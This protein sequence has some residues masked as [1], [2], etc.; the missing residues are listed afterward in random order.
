[1]GTGALS[2]EAK[3]PGCE[4][5]HSPSSSAEVKER[6]ELYLYSPNML[7]WRRAHLKAQGQLHLHLYVFLNIRPRHGIKI[8]DAVKHNLKNRF[9]CFLQY[10]KPKLNFIEVY[11]TDHST[12]KLLNFLTRWATVSFSRTMFH[13]VSSVVKDS[14]GGVCTT[15]GRNEK[16]IQSFGRKPEGKKPMGRPIR[17]WKDDTGMYLMETVWEEV[18]WIHLAQNRGQ[19][20]ALVYTVMNIRFT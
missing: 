11:K 17:R 13:G 9:S 19:W 14:V 16:C 6:V 15:D 4:A 10:V 8:H 1:M 3:R 12:K 5:D 18:D 2:L 20:Q 7:S